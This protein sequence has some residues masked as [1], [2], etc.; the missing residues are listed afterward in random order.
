MQAVGNTGDK[1]LEFGLFLLR[2]T[3]GLFFLVWS[4]DKLVNTSHAL[5]IFEKFY[6][7]SIPSQAA[8]ALGLVQTGIVLAFMAG[9]AKAWATGALIAMHTVSVGATWSHLIA[10]YGGGPGAV[11][12]AGVPVLAGL[13]LLWLVREKDRLWTLS[14]N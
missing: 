10:P 8:V 3:T 1:R 11:F 14:K 9:I 2:I 6:F 5:E 13:V 12:W 4:I 7:M